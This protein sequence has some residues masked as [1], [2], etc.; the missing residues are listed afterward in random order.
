[1]NFTIAQL[2]EL[3]ERFAKRQLTIV[4]V[5]FGS[6]KGS[7]AS[8]KDLIHASDVKMYFKD[9]RVHSISRYLDK[10]IE[11]Q[12]FTPQSAKKQPTLF[13]HV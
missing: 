9:G 13:D 1:M 6:S 11:K 10:P 7:P 12:L 4:M 5:D 3:R 2:K 8:G